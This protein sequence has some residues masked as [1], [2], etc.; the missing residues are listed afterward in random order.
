MHAVKRPILLTIICVLG[1]IWIVFTFPGVFSPEVKRLGTWY[2][3]LFGL[4]VAFSFISFIGIWHMKRWGVHL[5]I[6][7]F[8]FKQ[9]LHVLTDKM[10]ISAWIGVVFSLFF[11]ISFLCYYKRMDVNL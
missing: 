9:I 5:Y 4:V 1:Y 6:A 2:P 11:I 8:F 7:T 10:G 3:A